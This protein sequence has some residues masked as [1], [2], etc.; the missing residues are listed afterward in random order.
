MES[1]MHTFADLSQVPLTALYT[2]DISSVSDGIWW[3]S[4][5]FPAYGA[6]FS[7]LV[8]LAS[9]VRD[10]V[11]TQKSSGT[12]EWETPEDSAYSSSL[13]IRRRIES[14]GGLAIF[15]YRI[16]QLLGILSLLGISIA[17]FVL[18]DDD[19]GI[20][21]GALT[22]SRTVQ[23]VQVV[24]YAYLSVLVSLQVVSSGPLSSRAYIHTSWLL[25]LLWSIYL[26][27]D[28]WPLATVNLVPADK[29]EGLFLWAKIALLSLTGF[30]V[31]IVIPKKYTPV[32]PKEPCEP[33]PEQTA[34]FLSFNTYTFIAPV[35][36]NAY[37]M[38]H[39]PFD[40][41]PPL[42]DYDH[43]KNIVGRSFPH[44]DP[45]ISKSRRHVGLK[46]IR[47]FW[48]ELLILAS[49]S[50]TA[51]IGQ[52]A[53][54]ISINNLLTYFET[55]GEGETVRPWFWIALLFFGRIFQT[56][57]DQ[58]FIF[59][60]A[61]VNVRMQAIIT[62]L[63]FEHALR[64]RMKAGTSEGAESSADNS[65]IPTPDTASQVGDEG[66]ASDAG[67]SDT[68][69]EQSASSSTTIAPVSSTSSKGKG[70]AQ[71]E[72]ET[73]K[74][75]AEAPKSK[76]NIIGR[77]NNLASSDLSSLDNCSM[78]FV[79]ALVESPFQITLCM[80]F[81]YRIMGWST[82]VGIAAMLLSLPVPGFI[83]ARLQ[84]TQRE[85]MER[86]D[87]RVQ[88]VTEMMNVIRMIKLF[89]W[90]PRIVTQLNEK[91][92]LELVSVKKNRLYNLANNLCNYLIPILIMIATFST[93]AIFMKGELT[94]SKVFSAIAVFDMLRINIQAT[95]WIISSL[96]QSN[97]SLERISD[98][99]YN[100]ELIDEFAGSEK[101]EAAE[102]FDTPIP[103]EHQ[104]TIGIRHASFTW[105]ADSASVAITPGGTRRRTFALNIEDEVF[106]Q[107][108]K[109][110][111]IVGPTGA[112]KTSLLMALLGEM[113]YIPQGPD[114]FVNLP[115]GGG[116]A[117]AA[118]ESWVQ[119]D[120]IKNNIVFGSQF[121]EVRY[122]KV[123][124]QCAL[125]RDLELFDAGDE[126]EVGE[127]GLT[128]S[129]GQKARITLARAVYSN[130][131]IVLLDDILAALDVHTSR[132]IVEKCLKG[133]LIRGRTVILVTHNVAMVSPIADFLVDM[134]SDGR[135]LSQGSLSSALSMDS[136]LLREVE[137]EQQVLE[138]AEQEIDPTDETE[139]AAEAQKS[140]GKLVVAEEIE[141]GH[142]GWDA[143]KLF[144]ANVS[145]RPLLF[146]IVYI[147]GYAAKH[148]ISNIQTWYLG[149]WA[150]QYEIHPPSEVAVSHYLTVYT[151]LVG[152]GTVFSAFCVFYYVFGSIRASRIIHEKLVVS[153][154]GTTLRW[155]DKTP[156]ARIITRCTEDIQTLD[157]RFSRALEAFVEIMVYLILKMFGV[158]VFS[159]IFI[160]PALLVALGGVICGNIYMKAQL[161]V[162]RE[163]SAAKAPVLGHFGAAIGGITS[164][165]AYG[166]QDAFKAEAYRRIDRYSRVAITH[167]TLNRWVMFRVDTLGVIFTASLG[168]YLTYIT[169]LSASNTGFSFAMAAAFSGVILDAVRMFNEAEISGNSLERIQ[170]YL[171]IEQEP[172][173]TPEGVP[174]AYWPASGKLEVEELSARYSEDG[175]KVLHNVSFDV[176]SGER[177]GIVGR[178]GSG[179]SSLTLALLR[180][181]LTEGI[182]RYDGLST[183][184]LNLDALRSNIT[185][186][187]QVPELLSGSLRQNLDPFSEHDDAVLNDALRSAGLFSVQDENDQSRITLDSQIAGGGANLSVGQ[188]QILALAR[189]IVR[190][191]KLLILDEA[192]SAIDYE[193][194]SIIQT[195]LR[196]ELGKDVTLLTVAHRLQTIMDSDKIMVLDAGRIVEFGKPSKLLKNEKGLLRALVDESG[197]KEK[198]YTMANAASASA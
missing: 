96:V 94:A 122:N 103:D 156:T 97:V 38:R 105:A 92:D 24:V 1:A 195:S 168:I 35:I 134:G 130:A 77:I 182:V 111:L 15:S 30:V 16:V 179:K 186:I 124:D 48:L 68:V 109:I 115:R 133:D 22:A 102:I 95:F 144:L 191:S 174:P 104:D 143:V 12:P 141:E 72:P 86:T 112:G 176:A 47:V 161:C 80:I 148:L 127:K 93:Y 49:M 89:G 59:T 198:L 139:K 74:T 138:K 18:D 54:P 41:L 175:P 178:T 81:L 66:H 106:F 62:E 146:W 32:N 3:N 5:I 44:L 58:W 19:I 31:P 137:E 55:G 82:F 36:W 166:V 167:N 10:W 118:Q 163:M 116:V 129:G 171:V 2:F 169:R 136:K 170:Q 75:S 26:Y 184:K 101:P 172:K 6:G 71:P 90:E 165:R 52:F 20:L 84:G 153:I 159:P 11:R 56:V 87:S 162:K 8:L 152:A 83:T 113:H 25:F 33:N 9:A 39:L 173:A 189:A 193:T 147:S 158:V 149:V 110:N 28:V 197:D 128:L 135:I 123:L 188:R 69:A 73:T 23:A 63:V 40:M 194:D 180:C 53:A 187:P 150:A 17:Q 29:G 13:P 50:V 64:V 21:R 181:I 132:H 121:D 142:V 183:N 145:Q 151:A 67:D 185:I 34:S 61:R 76:K 42:P 65:A 140:S 100:T 27:R 99:L 108:G 125:R 107:R 7:V 114:S 190:R 79:Y 119:N 98:F 126:T 43:L 160:F 70:K 88:T 14:I 192:T 117:Y 78:Y 46:L 154:L 131:E 60:T 45:L 164:I 155:L 85:K 51:V 57:C 196:T 120:T 37:R 157:N 177:V 91:R 4:L